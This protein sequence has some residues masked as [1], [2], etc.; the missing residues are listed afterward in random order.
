MSLNGTAFDS[1]IELGDLS[2]ETR[3]VAVQRANPKKPGTTM[4]VRL[5]AYVNGTRTYLERAVA[6]SAARAAWIDA[7][8]IKGD[9]GKPIID[10]ETGEPSR[11][12]DPD[13]VYWTVFLSQ[14]LRAVIP[15]LTA[16]EALVLA[17]QAGAATLLEDLGWFRKRTEE[18]AD[19]EVEGEG[20]PIGD[21]SSPDS[22]STTTARGRT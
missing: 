13:G 16:D 11:S 17:Y 12:A 6:F 3:Q 7:T 8:T 18:P 15:D 9:D 14:A 19:P 22:V 21:G 10:P 20:R 1:V 5:T 4:P 2:P